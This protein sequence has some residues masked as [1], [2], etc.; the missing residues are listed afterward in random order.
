MPN[1]TRD[2]IIHSAKT[3]QQ[4]KSFNS[5]FYNMKLIWAQKFKYTFTNVFELH[6][7]GYYCYCSNLEGQQLINHREACTMS[8]TFLVHLPNVTMTTRVKLRKDDR[9]GR[10]QEGQCRYDCQFSINSSHTGLPCR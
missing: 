8:N 2:N 9:S 10:Q 1:K 4:P 5:I 3:N 7:Y 6:G